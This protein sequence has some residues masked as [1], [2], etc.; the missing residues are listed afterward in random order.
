MPFTFGGDFV[1]KPKPTKPLKIF[2]EKR[3]GK[4]LTIIKG[5]EGDLKLLASELKSKFS[6]GGSVKDEQIELQGDHVEKVRNFLN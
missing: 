4:T 1:E 2:I 3:K 5:A 6:C